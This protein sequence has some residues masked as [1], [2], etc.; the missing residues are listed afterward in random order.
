MNLDKI[1]DLLH[2]DIDVLS[3]ISNCDN[4]IDDYE[5]ILAAFVCNS[6]FHVLNDTIHNK[7]FMNSKRIARLLYSCAKKLGMNYL[8]DLLHDL[9]GC[10]QSQKW[11]FSGHIIEKIFSHIMFIRETIKLYDDSLVLTTKNPLEFL[12]NGYRIY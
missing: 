6:A 3:G 4:S 1:F 11:E 2:C 5:E 9:L 7:D 8:A 12:S 10:I